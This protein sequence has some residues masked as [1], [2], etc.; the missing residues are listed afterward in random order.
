M[1][2]PAGG[3]GG[4]PTRLI[5]ARVPAVFEIST[6]PGSTTFTKNEVNIYIRV[7]GIVNL[8]KIVI[9]FICHGLSFLGSTP[10]GWLI[11][12]LP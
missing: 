7:P 4:E 10:E 2:G 6:S 9:A 12:S 3:G 11:S 5:P 1:A 8:V